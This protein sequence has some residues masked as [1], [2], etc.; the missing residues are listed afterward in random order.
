[1]VEVAK[2]HYPFLPVGLLLKDRFPSIDRVRRLA[3]PVLVI[4]GDRDGIVPPSQSRALFEAAPSAL[5][6]FVLIPGA[7]H[8]D[9][10]LQAG[11]GLVREVA[12]FVRLALDAGEGG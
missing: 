4:A 10:E 6:R 8:N 2:V 11:P 1:M 3:C 9:Y 5:K 7:D 12:D